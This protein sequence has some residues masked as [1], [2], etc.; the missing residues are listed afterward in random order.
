MPFLHLQVSG[1]PFDRLVAQ[2]LQLGLTARMAGTLGKKAELTSV[3]VE[4][5]PASSSWS[6]GGTPVLAAAHLDA[7]IT[8]GTN[9]AAEKA[10]FIEEA[11]V[12]LQTELGEDL[13]LATYVVLNEV[14]AGSWGYSG[15]T[16]AHRRDAASSASR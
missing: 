5:V 14:P 16:Q 3:L 9:T 8:E 13:P 6:V 7:K 2:R 4:H 15:L 1:Q 12:L 11:F 10:R